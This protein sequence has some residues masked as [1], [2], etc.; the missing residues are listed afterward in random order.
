MTNPILS[1]LEDLR[2]AKSQDVWNLDGLSTCLNSHTKE[3]R[4][5]IRHKDSYIRCTT[6]F[7][8]VD[9]S[10][11]IAMREHAVWTMGSVTMKRMDSWD[12]WKP[13]MSMMGYSQPLTP[14]HRNHLPPPIPLHRLLR[15]GCRRINGVLFCCRSL[16]RRRRQT[17]R[18]RG[19]VSKKKLVHQFFV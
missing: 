11:R 14:S 1:L 3:N 19:S 7:L 9:A 8:I 6:M 18:R 2:F 16:R 4:W 15:D 5:V 13:R 12:K 17:R 10:Y